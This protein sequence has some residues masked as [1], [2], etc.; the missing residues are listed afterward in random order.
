MKKIFISIGIIIIVLFTG[1][2]QQSC[3]KLDEEVYSDYTGDLFFQDPNN[4]I[5]AFG[6]AYTNLYQV[7]GHKFGLIGMDCGT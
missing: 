4:L 7:A 6:V 3:T 1:L 2:V 5:Y